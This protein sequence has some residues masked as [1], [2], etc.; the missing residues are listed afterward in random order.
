ML[1]SK[2]SWKFYTSTLTGANSG[3]VISDLTECKV[4]SPLT[5]LTAERSDIVR[6][7]YGRYLRTEMADL[8]IIRGSFMSFSVT[9]IRPSL[10]WSNSCI[11]YRSALAIYKCSRLKYVISMLSVVVVTKH[12]TVA[13]KAPTII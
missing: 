6:S 2:A 4:Y 12:A 1:F 10:I 3:F 9:T 11:V 13:T 5:P 7:Y 8:L